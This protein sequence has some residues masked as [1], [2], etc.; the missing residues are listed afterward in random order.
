[1]DMVARQQ[2]H[3][4]ADGARVEVDEVASHLRVGVRVRVRVRVRV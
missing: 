1:M 3:D 4:G 2:R